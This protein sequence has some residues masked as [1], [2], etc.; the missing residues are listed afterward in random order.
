MAWALSRLIIMDSVRNHPRR[1]GLTI[2]QCSGDDP[3]VNGISRVAHALH[4]DPYITDRDGFDCDILAGAMHPDGSQ[5]TYIEQRSKSGPHAVDVTI[6][7][8]HVTD[9]GSNRSEDIKSY[10]PF[11]GCNVR[12]LQWHGD[13]VVMVYREKHHTYAATYGRNWPPVFHPIGDRWIINGASL[14]YADDDGTIERLSVPE[15]NQVGKLS[16]S[17]AKEAGLFPGEL[18]DFL[19]W[20]E[21]AG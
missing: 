18:E 6:K 19:D 11:F 3:N 15:L 17:Q 13:S 12:Y 21:N 8:H 14:A 1:F 7:I 10:N 5:F 2:R 20:P 4:R 16:E 9:I